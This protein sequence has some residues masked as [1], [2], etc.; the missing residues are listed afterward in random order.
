MK[1]SLL[2]P[3]FNEEKAVEACVLSCLNQS[4]KFDEII[5]IDDCSSDKTPEILMLYADK[6]TVKRTPRNTGN[7]SRAQEFGLRFVT[8]DVFATTDADTILDRDFAKEVEKNFENDDVAAMAGYVVSRPYNWLTL[9]RSLDY[10]V[11]QNLHKLAQSYLDYIFVM[12]GAASAFRTSAFKKDITFDHDTVA[13]DLDFTYKLQ[14]KNLK[15]FYNR[16]AISYTQDPSTLKSYMNQMRRWY[17][18]GWQNLIKHFGM[19]TNPIKTL[20]LS[21]LYIEGIVFAFLAFIIPILNPFVALIFI[22]CYLFVSLCFGLWAAITEKR[23]ALLFAPFPYIIIIFINSAV[24]IE[25][26]IKELVLKQKNL[27]WFK[28][29][30]VFYE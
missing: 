11:G 7:K 24:F 15:I 27:A 2:V 26:F 1:I 16:K 4:R 14:D 9:C 12:P 13:E 18:G 8:G 22:S 5:F 6:I 17:G 3:C 28:P 20:E 30:R 19:E 23:P 29:E 25:Q 10:A 21:L